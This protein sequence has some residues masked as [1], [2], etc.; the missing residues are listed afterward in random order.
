LTPEGGQSKAADVAAYVK[1]TGERPIVLLQLTITFFDASAMMVDQETC[2]V[3]DSALVH[4]A[5][6]GRLDPG[7]GRYFAFTAK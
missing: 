6:R 2:E 1:N 5:D 7:Q 3:V 4:S